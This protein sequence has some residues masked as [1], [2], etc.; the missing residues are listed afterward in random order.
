MLLDDYLKINI[1]KNF[2]VVLDHI[3]QTALEVNKNKPISLFENM[4]NLPTTATGFS[5]IIK[6]RNY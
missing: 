1:L 4:N 6:T 2:K 5:I 3:F